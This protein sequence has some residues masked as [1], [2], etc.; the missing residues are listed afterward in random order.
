MGRSTRPARKTNNL[1][2]Y[3]TYASEW[4]HPAGGKFRS[5]RGISEFRLNLLRR[6]VPAIHEKTVLDLGCGGGL[7]CAPLSMDGAMVIGVDLS[8]A[9]LEQARNHS[10]A[11]ARFFKA[12]VRS[13]PLPDRSADVV[14]IADVLDH[15][16]DYEQ[17]LA[18][19]RRLLRAGGCVFI[20]T[21]NRNFFSRLLAVTV[22]EN[23]GLIPKGTH[24]PALFIRP[25]ELSAAAE[26]QDFSVAFWQG[27]RPALRS[28]IREWAIYFAPCRSLAVAYSAL[29]VAKY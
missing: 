4:W 23:I 17:V 8:A 18:E 26:R 25:E 6:W 13:V 27:E 11:T 7:L 20:N 3:E 5:L 16:P 24:D 28:T 9:S 21:I 14:L 2:I 29:L 1:E 22:G 15:I 10:A 19:A 12:D